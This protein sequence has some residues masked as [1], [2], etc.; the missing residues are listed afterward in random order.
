[1][2]I[3]LLK[4]AFLRSRDVSSWVIFGGDKAVC[5]QGDA[6]PLDSMPLRHRPSA[7]NK[8]SETCAMM[9]HD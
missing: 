4:K 8:W 2:S 3:G 7:S 5:N 1:M 6:G 9:A